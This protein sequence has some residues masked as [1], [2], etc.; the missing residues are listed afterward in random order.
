M[1]LRA[2]GD[3]EARSAAGVLARR[4]GLEVVEVHAKPVAAE[5]VEL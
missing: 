3:L 4:D 5:V 2:L 1:T